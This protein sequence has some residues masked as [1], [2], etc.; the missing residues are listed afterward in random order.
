MIFNDLQIEFPQMPHCRIGKFLAQNAISFEISGEGI[1][2]NFRFVKEMQVEEHTK[3]AQ[4]PG[5]QIGFI[6]ISF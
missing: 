1:T 5:S 3:L 4:I 6:G 2:K